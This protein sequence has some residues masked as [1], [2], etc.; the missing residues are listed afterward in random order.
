M[1]T[2][3]PVQ[4]RLQDDVL[5]LLD[6]FRRGQANPPSRAQAGRELIRRGL[7]GQTRNQRQDRGAHIFGESSETGRRG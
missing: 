1:A 4:I 7:G 3:T 6:D 2:G 5:R